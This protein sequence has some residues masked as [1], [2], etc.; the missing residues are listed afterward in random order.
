M[1][2]KKYTI[3]KDPHTFAVKDA[4][5]GDTVEV[6]EQYVDALIASRVIA[7]TGSD[8]AKKAEGK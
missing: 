3:L 7:P 2:T 6:D 8:L 4:K 5:V 1:A